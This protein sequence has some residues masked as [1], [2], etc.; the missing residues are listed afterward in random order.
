M[1]GGKD[2]FYERSKTLSEL[3]TLDTA[4]AEDCYGY[5]LYKKEWITKEFGNRESYDAWNVK[6]YIFRACLPFIYADYRKFKKNFR[7]IYNGFLARNDKPAVNSVKEFA[8]YA[9]RRRNDCEERYSQENEDLFDILKYIEFDKKAWSL[10][11]DLLIEDLYKDNFNTEKKLSGFTKSLKKIFVYL[12]FERFIGYDTYLKIYETLCGQ[13][14]MIENFLAAEE[15]LNDCKWIF[16]FNGLN[17]Y[18]SNESDIE[19]DKYFR[20]LMLSLWGKACHILMRTGAE[21]TKPRLKGNYCEY[22]YCI[23]TIKDKICPVCGNTIPETAENALAELITVNLNILKNIIPRESIPDKIVGETFDFKRGEPYDIIDGIEKIDT[24]E[25]II[26]DL[27][28]QAAGFFGSNKNFMSRRKRTCLI[29]E[30]NEGEENDDIFDN[31]SENYFPY[32]VIVKKQGE[33]LPCLDKFIKT[34]RQL[35]DCDNVN[36]S[37]MISMSA[38]VSYYGDNRPERMINDL[39]QGLARTGAIKAAYAYG[40]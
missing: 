25:V 28:G 7:I 31:L 11:W 13:F 19:T 36:K 3:K 27:N 15:F 1:N 24:V 26:N 35:N 29:V 18:E 37:K 6:F 30:C 33:G 2:Y 14:F 23:V 10:Q 21:E 38:W 32:L 12:L 20:F 39:A 17:I 9:I 4:D 16:G 5:F 40:Y 34:E 8:K 22:C